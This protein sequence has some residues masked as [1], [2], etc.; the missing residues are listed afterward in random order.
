[1]L[2][3]N[4]Y[5]EDII[6]GLNYIIHR[7]KDIVVPDIQSDSDSDMLEDEDREYM[8]HADRYT[9][10]IFNKLYDVD[11]FTSLQA[12]EFIKNNIDNIEYLYSDEDEWDSVVGDIEDYF[13][14]DFV[15]RSN[16]TDKIYK[17]RTLSEFISICK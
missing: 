2:D 10:S 4:Q 7:N 11:A 17:S 14:G 8:N 5:K 6:C 9:I 15:L 12:A 3:F 1:V 13:N 16:Y